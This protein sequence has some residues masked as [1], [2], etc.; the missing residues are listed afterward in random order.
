[1][2]DW[3]D[4]LSHPPLTPPDA[5]FGPVWSVLYLMIAAALVLHLRADLRR[6]PRRWWPWALWGLHLVANAAWTPLFFSLQSPGWALVDILVLDLTLAALIA[7]AW[8]TRRVASA[9]LWPYAVWV[10]FATYLNIG[11]LVLNGW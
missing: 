5:V 1:M 7:V 2:N 6:E 8:R 4:A 11:F 10:G 3:Y 9:L